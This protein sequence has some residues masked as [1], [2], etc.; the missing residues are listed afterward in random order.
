MCWPWGAVVWVMVALMALTRSLMER[1]PMPGVAGVGDGAA[2][3]EDGAVIDEEVGE[4]AVGAGAA[5]WA[6]VSVVWGAAGLWV[7]V[8]LMWVSCGVCLMR[9]V[10][11]SCAM[12]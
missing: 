11:S 7:R 2:P 1:R 3:A 8:M 10:M 6:M 5:V 12:R 9:L 4:G